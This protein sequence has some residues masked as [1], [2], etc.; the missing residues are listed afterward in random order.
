MKK[1][2]LRLAGYAA[3]GGLAEARALELTAQI[4]S[5]LGHAHSRG[6][7]HRD[8]K[9]SNIILVKEPDG[10]ETVR[11]VDFGIAKL[12]RD[13]EDSPDLTKTGEVFGTPLYMSPEQCLGQ[14]VDAGSDIYSLGC[15]LFQM[16][17]GHPPFQGGSSFEILSQHI[18]Q[19]VVAPSEK[20][21]R[22]EVK[23]IV[24]TAMSKDRQARYKGMTDFEN[25]LRAVLS[26]RQPIV[27]RSG[28][29]D[30][31]FMRSVACGTFVGILVVLI[32]YLGSQLAF[33]IHQERTW[34]NGYDQAII[35]KDN[36][37][38]VAA[39]RKLKE[40]L[41]V[42]QR[43]NDSG[44]AMLTL[45]ALAAV[46]DALGKKEAAKEHRQTILSQSVGGKRTSNQL[47]NFF[48]RVAVTLFLIG[49]LL[50]VIVILMFAPKSSLDSM[51]ARNFLKKAK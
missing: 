15:V 27:A 21:M 25:D 7:I 49:L 6:V 9:P 43:L 3:S 29:A 31:K 41:P 20:P 5:A 44:S 18:N 16:L 48:M 23:A 33:S 14:S 51:F 11:I 36:G 4:C 8:V 47:S 12:K 2:R 37:E 19:E 32:V 13:D 30:Y 28:A 42:A 46:E 22:R 24:D 26:G 39:E 45:N 38:N 50:S 10:T 35:L 40:I 34:R 1:V 17:T